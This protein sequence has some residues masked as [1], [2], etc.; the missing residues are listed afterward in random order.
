MMSEGLI[1][2]SGEDLINCNDQ[3]FKI[4]KFNQLSAF[5]QNSSVVLKNHGHLRNGTACEILKLG[6]KAW[7][8]GKMKF[9]LVIDFIPDEIESSDSLE[10]DSSLDQIRQMINE[11]E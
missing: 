11:S 8:K 10:P 2:F 6:E 5:D 4:N 3:I 1:E 7:R 9:R